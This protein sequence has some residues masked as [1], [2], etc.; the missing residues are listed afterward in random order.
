M[1]F[2]NEYFSAYTSAKMSADDVHLPLCESAKADLLKLL[3]NE[4]GYTWLSLID[5]SRMETV[6]VHNDH[7][8]LILERGME[9]TQAVPHPLG[10]CV[11]TVSPTVIAAIKDLVCNYQCCEGGCPCVSASFAGSVIPDATVGVPWK[12]SVIFNGDAPMQ[13]A[14]NGGPAW[15]MV[16]ARGNVLML[17]GT[18]NRSGEYIISAAASNCGGTVVVSEALK[19]IVRE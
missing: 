9:G 4:D 6:K 10:T 16:Q 15:L 12:G 11:R 17:S 5:E 18:P 2:A 7:G 19:L 8:T 3:E 14:V 13:L 1:L